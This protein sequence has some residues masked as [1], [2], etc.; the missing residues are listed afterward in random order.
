MT[1]VYK[2]TQ[3]RLLAALLALSL[4]LLNSCDSPAPP[5]RDAS[6]DVD[7][8]DDSTPDA[9]PS[10]EP[11]DAPSTTQDVGD[12]PGDVP[13]APP[14]DAGGA[15]NAD[16]TAPDF[17]ETDFCQE[18]STFGPVFQSTIERWRAQDDR[19]PP[20]EGGLLIVGSSSV[21]RWDGF[22]RAYRAHRPIQR[23]F[24]G[25]QLGEVALFAQDLVVRHN[26]R[27]VIVFAGTNDVAADVPPDVVVTRFRCL[28]Q[29]IGLGLG[30]DRPVFF[31]GIT[32]TP[33]RW[34]T[35][36]KADAVNQSVKALEADDPALR[37]VDVPAAFLATGSP[38]DASLFVSDRLHLSPAGYALWDSALNPAVTST[39]TPLPGVEAP[40]EPPPAPGT[41]WLIDL[42]PNNDGDGEDTPSPDYLGQHWNNWHALNGD[43]RALPG[44]HL[45]DL[46]SAQGT[47]TPVDLV[48]AGGFGANGWAN[49]GFRWPQRDALDDLA[50][51]SATGD[52]FYSDGDDRPGGLFLKDLDPARRYTLRLFASRDDEQRRVTRFIISGADEQTLTLQTSGPGAGQGGALLNDDDVLTFTG[53]R[54][55]AW[56]QLFIEVDVVEG[57][58]GYLSLVALT[59][60]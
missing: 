20:P 39:L 18:I 47:Q 35:W 30:W 60:E 52:F 34:E 46:R 26:P 25:A 7:P 10:P 54:P 40:P 23:G 33:A 28:R 14:D 38:P 19:S 37:Y 15:S 32:P 48:I 49:G 13:S 5:P 51:G 27:A 22:A 16:A 41:R 29:R 50:V 53:L 3:P 9:D 6:G 8:R 44:E 1:H 36:D 55:D 56:G 42:G 31:I 4:G 24:G 59:V 21:R 45:D 12:D 17:A 57:L 11:A 58:Y 2:A 43:G